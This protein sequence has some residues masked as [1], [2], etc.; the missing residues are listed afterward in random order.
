[1]VKVE[2][3]YAKEEE[4]FWHTPVRTGKIHENLVTYEHCSSG[5]RVSSK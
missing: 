1:M 4:D 3:L 5:L 2:E